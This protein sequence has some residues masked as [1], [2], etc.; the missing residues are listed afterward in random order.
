AALSP[1][2]EAPSPR[3]RKWRWNPIRPRASFPATH[4]TPIGGA[5]HPET[6]PAPAPPWYPNHPGGGG[7]PAANR[8]SPGARFG[9]SAARIPDEAPPLRG[10][11][12]VP[13]SGPAP[14]PT[15]QRGPPHPPPDEPP[16]GP[17]APSIRSRKGDPLP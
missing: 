10:K 1:P 11:R 15:L 7:W 14:S 12:H 9:Q 3:L 16:D 17:T 4:R 2:P 8:T 13:V 6:N 5:P